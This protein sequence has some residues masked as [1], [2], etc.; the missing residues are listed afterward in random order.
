M[1]DK[2]KRGNPDR[3]RININEEYELRQ[4]SQ[5]FNVTPEELKRAVA[6]VGDNA[7]AVQRELRKTA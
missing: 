6:K 4:W 3:S 5:K 2:T 7:D 1:D